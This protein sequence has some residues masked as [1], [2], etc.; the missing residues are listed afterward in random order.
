MSNASK[1]KVI[2]IAYD[3]LTDNLG[4]SQIL[5]YLKILSKQ[6]FSYTVFSYEKPELYEANKD[7]IEEAIEG[8]DIRWIPNV[9]HKKPPMIS[10][11]Q[12]VNRGWK[13]LKAMC[14]AGE[15]FDVVHCRSYI[16][17]MLGLRLKR[18][19]GTRYYFDMRGWFADERKESGFWSGF[20]YNL[21]YNYFKNLEKTYFRECDYAN[22]LTFAGQQEIE[23]AGLK[24]ANLVSVIPT[25]VDLDL[26]KEFDP[27]IR[28]AVRKELEIPMDARVLVYSGT[29]EGKYR[30]ESIMKVYEAMLLIDPNAYFLLLTT[31]PQDYV[32][33]RVKDYGMSN[34]RTRVTYSKFKDV[35]RYLM[36]CDLGMIMYDNDFSVIG[37]SPTKLGEYWACG[38]PAISHGDYG[39][40]RYLMDRYPEGGALFEDFTVEAY[41]KALQQVIDQDAGKETLR[42]YAEDYFD[43]KKGAQAYKEVLDKLVKM[44]GNG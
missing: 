4:Q 43:V 39:D 22:S 33:Q 5:A 8:L 38:V 2:Y 42:G 35:H 25:C 9:Y 12:D 32:L 40:L 26:F 34:D 37:R 16:A 20:P 3:G 27:N 31:T 15:R 19:Y 14:D 36:A 28:E 17:S 44:N 21:I 29:I 41:R 13:R 11:F 6:G 30:E 7:T 23:R 10:T 24:S 1:P 18:N